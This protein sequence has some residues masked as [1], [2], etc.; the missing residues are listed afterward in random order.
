MLSRK[1]N[2]KFK[3]GSH[4][5]VIKSVYEIFSPNGVLELGSGVHS[6]PYF[7]DKDVRFISLEND[8][9]WHKKVT[10]RKKGIREGADIIYHPVP[11]VNAKTKSNGLSLE[12]EKEV[13]DYYKNIIHDNDIDFLFID[14]FKSLRNIALRGLHKYCDFTIFHDAEADYY[15]YDVES[16]DRNEYIV[17]IYKS[18]IPNTGI[19][20]RKK[21]EDKIDELMN[22]IKINEKEYCN[23]YEKSCIFDMDIL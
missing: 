3:Y 2:I 9:G 1:G 19:V 21:Y 17:M 4:M 14:N 22:L 18:L 11:N 5:P 16:I 20:I 10:K 12:T 13:I 6:T 8:K 7:I 23:R 15:D